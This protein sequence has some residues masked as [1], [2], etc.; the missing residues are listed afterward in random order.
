MPRPW[1]AAVTCLKW[2]VAPLSPHL[3]VF[4][5]HSSRS[6]SHKHADARLEPV[7]AAPAVPLLRRIPWIA[8]V[9]TLLV[10]VAAAFP[11]DAVRDAITLGVVPEAHID[12]PP[13]YLA[14]APLSSVLDTLT[15]LGA[16]Q[17]VVV[18]ITVIVLFAVVRASRAG[19]AR[20]RGDTA[21]TETGRALREI[22]SAAFLLG[23]IVLVYAAAA[24]LPRPMA[25]L[26][27]Q[28]ND[29]ILIADFHAH[30][31]Y[32]HDGRPDWDPAD[33][34]AWHRAAGFD[35]A[36]I[37]DHRTV[38]GAELGIA[39]NPTVAGQG[40]MLLQALEVGWHG[41]HVNILGA[42][43]FYKGVTTADL[44]D[45]DEQALTLASLLP[46]REPM[47]IQTFP[48]R[49][50]SVPL[51]KG[52]RTAGV[53][54]IEVIDGAP[55][56]LDQTRI[57][58]SRIVHLADSVNIAMVAGSD[59]HGWG[60]AAAGW[61]LL[62]VP[63]WRGMKTDSLAASIE[64]SLRTGRE[65]TRVVERRIP[66]ELNGGNALELTLTLPIVVWSMFTTL[67]VDERVIWLVWTWALVLAW[68]LTAGWRHRRR[69]P[70]VA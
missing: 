24:L 45:V 43:R 14:V 36:Y 15:L 34:R 27:A 52:P 9:I 4:V 64:Q 38:Q 13:G 62:I 55:R 12:L 50:D 8:V 25:A 46:G 49:L 3:L 7:P 48:G 21:R 63:G 19:L 20:R 2:R 23:A 58:R 5:A 11:E 57:L 22:G 31:R 18:L 44:R 30:T 39:D 6:R 33:V 37:S 54:A 69:L 61:T 17:H 65:A 26:V 59:N 29:V 40:E 60:Y 1:H 28:P 32:S 51:A 41:E 70:R 35:A 66:G 10:L 16:R 42:N 47:V 56:G 53:R 67:S 68:R